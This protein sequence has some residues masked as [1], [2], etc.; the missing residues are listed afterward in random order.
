ME[1]EAPSDTGRCCVIKSTGSPRFVTFSTRSAA[2][3]GSAL[4]DAC[5]NLRAKLARLAGMDPDSARFGDGRIEAAGQSRQLVDLVGPGG[6]DAD[7]EIVP[8]KDVPSD[9]AQPENGTVRI[10]NTFRI[11]EPRR[12]LEISLSSSVENTWAAVGGAA[13]GGS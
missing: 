11:A 6:I 7:G 13:P 10:T 12:N 2:S 1:R 5:N 4:F 9:P 8:G 3:S